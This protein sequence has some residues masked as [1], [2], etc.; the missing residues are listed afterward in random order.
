MFLEIA[1][2]G[3]CPKCLILRHRLGEIFLGRTPQRFPFAE[4]LLLKRKLTAPWIIKRH[5]A[6]R[7]IEAF[8]RNCGMVH[9]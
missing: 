1:P 2:R 6:L 3:E 4:I 8:S 7:Y 9:L 5:A